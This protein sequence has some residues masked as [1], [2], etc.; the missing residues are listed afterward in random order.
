VQPDR[1]GQLPGVWVKARQPK[2]S[3]RCIDMNDPWAFGWS[4]LLTI[5]GQVLTV[6]GFAITIGIAWFG[7]R[8]F[9]RWRRE[10]IEE[11]RIE[12]A[13][14]ALALVY[15]SKFVFD[16]IRSPMSFGYEWEDMP[17]KLGN[18]DHQRNAR[19]PFYAILKRIE[20]HKDFFERAWKM[21]VKCTALFGPGMEETFLLMQRARREIEVSAGMLVRDPEP[22]KTEG[23]EKTWARFKAD[24]WEPYGQFA[25][26]GD[27]VG[28]KL[29]EFRTTMEAACRPVI[30][31]EYGKVPRESFVDRFTTWLRRWMAA[32]VGPQQ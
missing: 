12:T 9:E 5:F 27:R 19:G 31:R 2:N 30:D 21:Q 7:F 20:A 23:N 4:Q 22:H 15:E 14:E 1:R 24:V 16:N 25:E 8:T 13:I 29:A 3:E 11:K 26:G 32:S 18:D 6:V 17:D 28:E 10:K